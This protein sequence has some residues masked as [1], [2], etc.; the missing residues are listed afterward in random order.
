VSQFASVNTLLDKYK[1]PSALGGYVQYT[2]AV[3]TADAPTL[4]TAVEALH[5]NLALIAEK[6]A[7]A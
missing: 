2:A 1:D 6:V 5:E 4:S 3:K 7:T